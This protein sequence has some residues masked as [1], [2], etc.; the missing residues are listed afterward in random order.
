VRLKIANPRF[1]ELDAQ[2]KAAKAHRRPAARERKRQRARPALSREIRKDITQ[3]ARRL[4]FIADPNARVFAEE[5]E[6]TGRN[7]WRGLSI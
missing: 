1:A 5:V 2:I 7:G 6:G 4:M 3:F